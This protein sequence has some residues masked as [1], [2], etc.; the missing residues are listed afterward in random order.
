METEPCTALT[1]LQVT[2]ILGSV[3][4]GLDSTFRPDTAVSYLSESTWNLDAL[5]RAVTMAL[6]QRYWGAHDDLRWAPPVE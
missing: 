3:R 1:T 4:G 5:L 2:F 6:R